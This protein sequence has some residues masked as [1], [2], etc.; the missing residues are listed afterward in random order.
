[1][2]ATSIAEIEKN[3]KTAFDIRFVITP[4]V[5]GEEVCLKVLEV[6]QE[7][8][9]K[10]DFSLLAHLG[11]TNLQI[12]KANEFLFGTMTLEGAPHLK[13][14]DYPVFDCANKCGKR[15]FGFAL[16]GTYRNDGLCA[17]IYQRSYQQN[18]QHDS[19]S[20]D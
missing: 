17:A 9:A 15:V 4:W 16:S 11:F 3:L 2:P 13:E 19:R 10:P 8:L 20:D 7:D 1:M 6:S 5:L 12:E 18:H 14:E